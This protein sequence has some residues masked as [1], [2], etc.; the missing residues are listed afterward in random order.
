MN[1]ELLLRVRDHILAEPRRLNMSRW[2]QPARPGNK[3]KIQYELG[4]Q[5][6]DENSVKRLTARTAPPCETVACIAGWAVTLNNPELIKG[7]SFYQINWYRRAQAALDLENDLLADRLF[8]PQYWPEPFCSA[9]TKCKTQR[10]RARLVA[11]V[12]NN[13]IKIYAS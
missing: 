1:T 10:Q 3:V 12:I 2:A 8:Y 7:L 13:F 11:K 5:I 4:E 9:Y 6:S